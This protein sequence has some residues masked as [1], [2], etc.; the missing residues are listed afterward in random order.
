MLQWPRK[1]SLLTFEQR[2]I[3]N[4]NIRKPE[5][6]VFQRKRQVQRPWVGVH[7]AHWQKNKEASVARMKWEERKM[8]GNKSQSWGYH[9]E[10]SRPL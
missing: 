8:V 1:V 5:K 7:L 10:T 3:Q 4:E 9:V 6:R 2:P